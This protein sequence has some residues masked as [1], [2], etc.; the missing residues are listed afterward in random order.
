MKR[1]WL[2]IAA[3]AA[4]SGLGGIAQAVPNDP[5][6]GNITFAGGAELNTS[7]AGTAT[8]VTGWTGPGSGGM[9]V[10]VSA[11]GS[12]SGLA[13]D[14]AS[15][16][17]PWFFNSGAVTGLWSVGGFTFNLTTSHIVFQGGSPAVVGV[18]GVGAVMGNGDAPEA[19]SW[20]FSTSNPGAAGSSGLVFSFQSADGTMGQTPPTP[21]VPD[22][23]TTAMLLGLGI[24]GLGLVKKHFLA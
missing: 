24:M 5:I 11:D 20:S 1:K 17:S 6:S 8:E 16:T 2:I 22:G 23:G 18:T 21:G 19:M 9:P 10:V 14:T 4:V 13:G 3:V 7:S 15:F 12:F